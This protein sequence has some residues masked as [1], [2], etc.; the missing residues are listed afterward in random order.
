MKLLIY[1]L[2]SLSLMAGYAKNGEKSKNEIIHLKY[3]HNDVYAQVSELQKGLYE[4]RVTSSDI[5]VKISIQDEEGI[6]IFSKTYTT[7]DGFTRQYDLRKVGL[8]NLKMV[9]EGGNT[10][11]LENL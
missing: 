3:S 2:L 8:E 4:V 6:T 11:I 7:K 5:P 1:S 9:I 10:H